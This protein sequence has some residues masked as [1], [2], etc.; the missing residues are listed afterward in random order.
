MIRGIG[1]VLVPEILD[2]HA[3][4]EFIEDSNKHTRAVAYR[5]AVT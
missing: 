4:D 5:W 1:V 3:F 2:A